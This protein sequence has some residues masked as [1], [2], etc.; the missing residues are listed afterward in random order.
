[1]SSLRPPGPAG[2][3]FRQAALAV[4][5]LL[6]ALAIAAKPA[7]AQAP[8]AYLLTVGPGDF[9][10][11]KFGHNAIWIH[12]PVAGTDRVYDWGRFDFNQPGFLPRFLKGRWIYSMGAADLQQFLATYQYYDRSV[13][14]QELALSAEQVRALQADVERNYLPQNR[15][16]RYDYF[17]D[18]CSTRV[19]D[20][21]DRAAGGAIGAATRGRPTPTTYRWHSERLVRRDRLS[22]AGL[23]A[24]LGP[25]SD[26]PISEWEE[27]FLPGRLQEH[28][29]KVR[30]RDAGGAVRPLV[31]GEQSVLS[32][33]RPAEPLAP[34]G[35]TPWFLAGGTLLGALL[36]LLARGSG[37]SGA[38]RAGLALL[39]GGWALVA[40]LGG[41][42]LLLL[43]GMTDHAIAYRNENLFH[44][45]PLALPLALLAPAAAWTRGR[46]GTRLA[47]GLA[48]AAL[49]SSVAGAVLQ[50]LPGV[51]QDNGALIAFALPANL[52]LALA[53]A[54]VARTRPDPARPA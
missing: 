2:R 52:G 54:R 43:W 10:W 36:I 1:M 44:L 38:S 51:D 28:V 25:A 47:V 53:M 26:R 27:M 30:L 3:P 4:F 5:A 8:R 29:R 19:R 12:D 21:L 42:L 9:V 34:P 37:R 24:G 40:G 35:D 50:L 7:T 20:A 33:T 14:A 13:A 6:A 49:A 15:E 17:R 22:Y 41:V 18:N 23:L 32:S 31:V 11:E 48:T 16:Y 45:S 39:G 46:H